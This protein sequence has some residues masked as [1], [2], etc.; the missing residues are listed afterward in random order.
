VYYVYTALNFGM[1]VGAVHLH[2]LLEE[3]GRFPPPFGTEVLVL[4]GRCIGAAIPR[5]DTRTGPEAVSLSGCGGL[6]R[7]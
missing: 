6:Y 1:K 4:A 2:V 5:P 3:N 7:T